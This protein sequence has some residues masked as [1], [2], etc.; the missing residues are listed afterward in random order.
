MDEETGRLRMAV[1]AGAAQA[2]KYKDKFP[3]ASE[4]EV[5]QDITDRASEIIEEID[6]EF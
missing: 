4:E 5:I 6:E 1:I 2:V 3:K